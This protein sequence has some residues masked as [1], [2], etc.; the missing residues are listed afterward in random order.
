MTTAKNL[1]PAYEVR[2]P[3]FGTMSLDKQIAAGIND[4]CAVGIS[5]HP[6]FGQTKHQAEQIRES[7]NNA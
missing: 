6:Y 5:G 1:H 7:F 3:S 4:W 2:N